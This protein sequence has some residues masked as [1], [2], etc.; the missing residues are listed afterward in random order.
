LPNAAGGTQGDIL[1]GNSE[2]TGKGASSSENE[3][4]KDHWMNFLIK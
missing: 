4:V 1:W 3:S 2:Q